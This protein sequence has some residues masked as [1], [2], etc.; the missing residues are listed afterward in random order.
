[1]GAKHVPAEVDPAE[2]ERLRSQVAGLREMLAEAIEAKAPVEQALLQA[3]ARYEDLTKRVPWSVVRVSPEGTYTDVNSAFAK[4]MRVERQDALDAAVGSLGEPQAWCEAIRHFASGSDKSLEIE[5]AIDLPEGKRHLLM[6]MARSRRDRAVSVLAL[7]QS[8]RFE[9]LNEARLFADAAER[10]N[11]AKSNFLAVMSHEIRTPMNGVIGMAALLADT[12]LSP[13]Q[14]EMIDTVQAS[15]SALLSLINDILD[16]SKIESGAMELESIPFSPLELVD[17][18]VA[19][20]RC[21][22]W[23]GGKQF[24]VT[25]NSALPRQIVGDPHRLRQ[26]VTN[27]LG[28]AL[29]FTAWG[30]RVALSVHWEQETLT[31]EVLDTGIGI[32][33]DRLAALFEPFSQADKSTTRRFGGT[34]LGLSITKRLVEGMLG[35][36]WVDSSPGVGSQFA[37]SIPCFRLLRRPEPGLRQP[38]QGVKVAVEAVDDPDLTLLLEHV[39]YRGGWIA[40]IDEHLE[41]GAASEVRVG[42]PRY[43]GEVRRYVPLVGPTGIELELPLPPLAADI[44]R[45]FEALLGASARPP[46]W[47]ASNRLAGLR[48]LVAEDNAVNWR[49]AKGMLTKMGCDVEWVANGRLAVDARFGQAFDLILMDVEMPEMDGLAATREIRRREPAGA[50]IAIV[51]ATANAIQEDRDRCL[52]AGMDAFLTKPIARDKL[53]SNMIEALVAVAAH[54]LDRTHTE[55]A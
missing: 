29:K 42:R 16:L 5:L 20:F 46:Q 18:A 21:A 7:D 13:A 32:P 43:H 36:I 45:V 19:M 9:A 37:V 39:R 11:E 26:I 1:M 4:L 44:D 35:T 41:T 30:E 49:V 8:D 22:A 33:Q 12:P 53:E 23:D 52:E 27:L 10:A 48:V 28:N 2:L 15:G 31:L 24:E 50:R 55:S 14:R 6:S 51:A 54:R 40:S 25:L 38:L 47:G 3:Q 34:G 17:G